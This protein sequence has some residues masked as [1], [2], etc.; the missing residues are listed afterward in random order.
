MP[1]SPRWASDGEQ[2]ATRRRATR[3]AAGTFMVLRGPRDS[4]AGL[5]LELELGGCWALLCTMLGPCGAARLLS[6]AAG[7]ARGFKGTKMSAS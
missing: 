4:R 1:D 7:R 5:E 6:P 3:A 2:A